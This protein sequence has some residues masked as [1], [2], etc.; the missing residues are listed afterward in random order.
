MSFKDKVLHSKL[1]S[2]GYRTKF[3][4]DLGM[5]Q[6]AW[7]TNKSVDLMA[8]LWLTERF[9]WVLSDSEVVVSCLV[10]AVAMFIF[11]YSWKNTGMWD[12]EVYV[13]T[14]KNPVQ[15]ELLDAARKINRGEKLE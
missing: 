14:A 10:F 8:F 4:L 7:F 12:V 9:G 15:K 2:I 6:V 13:A 3:Y 11:G 1:V 5:A